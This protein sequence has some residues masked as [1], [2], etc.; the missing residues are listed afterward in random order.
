LTAGESLEAALGDIEA[1][2]AERVRRRLA[3]A[4]ESLRWDRR[5]FGRD[6]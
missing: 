3:E 1:T 4:A 6:L 5:R 2:E